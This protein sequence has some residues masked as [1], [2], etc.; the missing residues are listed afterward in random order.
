MTTSA[1]IDTDATALIAAMGAAAHDAAAVLATT[2]T[3]TKAAALL[4]AAA[5][6]HAGSAGIEAANALENLAK[7]GLSASQAVEAL[8]AVLNLASAGGVELGTAAEFITKAVNGM[9]LEFAEAGRVADV[10]AMGANASNT[11]VTGLAHRL[12]P[13]GVT[14]LR[15]WP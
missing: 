8:P 15:G 7:S 10:L 4:A 9:G 2:P 6:L 12:A 5:A 13:R 1:S 3:A 14:V 11:S